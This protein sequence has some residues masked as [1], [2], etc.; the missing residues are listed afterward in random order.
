MAPTKQQ[1]LDSLAAIPAPGG[2]KLTE[3]GALSDIVVSDGKVFFSLT[4]DAAAVKAWEP[5]RKR[6]EETV[7][8]VP[9]VKS[10]MVAL[11]AERAAGAGAAGA[12][13][14][15][16]APAHGPRTEQGPA[17]VPGVKSIIAV[18]SGKGGVGKSTTAINLALGLR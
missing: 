17:G 5:V 11:T 9:G 7:R 14:P 18:A 4:V 16:P 10:A 1:I 13:R 15:G 3:A 8:A 2:K 12:P 6:V